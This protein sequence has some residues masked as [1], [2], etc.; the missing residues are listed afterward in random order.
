MMRTTICG[1]EFKNPVISASGTG[2]FGREISR[3]VDLSKL[4][5]FSTKGLTFHP[6]PGNDGERLY[7][8]AQ[9]LMNSIGL[10]NPSI[11]QF[12][13][14]DYEWLMQQG[15]VVI[16]N[17]GGRDLEE[18]VAGAKLLATTDIPMVELN[19]SCPNVKNGGM[20]MGMQACSAAEVVRAVK[21]VLP[22]PLMVKLSP[23]AHNLVEVAL[24]VQEAG[25]DCVSLVN[26]FNA[27][28][29]DIYQRKAV[30]NNTYAGLSGPAIKPIALRMVREV[31]RNLEIPVIGLGG[32]TTWQDAIEFIMA[33]ATAIQVGTA[34][35][36]DPASMENIILGME[37]FVD[38]QGIKSLSEIQ[39]II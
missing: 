36:L 32:I 20:A 39:G 38:Q 10:Q 4:G 3:W 33:G 5:G 29:V 31:S 13:E 27:L 26:T 25:A 8:T 30:F 23:N 14:Q 11:T 15:T 17:L 16:A 24:A 22:Q 21:A 12:L 19:I 34:T 2:G 9:G 35:L 18:Y 7:E 6:R 37:N 1:V 28:A